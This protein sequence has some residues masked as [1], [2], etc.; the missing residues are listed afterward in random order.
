MVVYDCVIYVLKQIE[1]HESTV[2]WE[3]QTRCVCVCQMWRVYASLSAPAVC[4]NAHLTVWTQKVHHS[5]S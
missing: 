2:R 4:P 3:G 5:Y 1:K